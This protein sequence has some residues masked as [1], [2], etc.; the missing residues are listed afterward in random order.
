MRSSFRFISTRWLAVL[1]VAGLALGCQPERTGASP[2]ELAAIEN[3]AKWFQYY[4]TKHRNKPPK[5]EEA[6]AGFIEEVLAERGSDVDIPSLFVS[7]RDGQKFVI[8]Y[9]K[10]AG[11]SNIPDYNVAAYE[12]EGSGGMKLVAFEAAWGKEVD[13][14]ELQS[15]LSGEKQ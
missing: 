10:L 8:Q 4:R 7:P 5:D 1:L 9:G 6:L 2:E 11:K 12:Q 13:E 15:L 3:I 14:A